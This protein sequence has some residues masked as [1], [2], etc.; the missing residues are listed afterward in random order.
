MKTF[1]SPRCVVLVMLALS[2]LAASSS[3]QVVA[4]ESM[5]ATRAVEK[6]AF[7]PKTFGSKLL[8]GSQWKKGQGASFCAKLGRK[9]LPGMR[10]GKGRTKTQIR[11]ISYATLASNYTKAMKLRT[12]TTK[13]KKSFKTLSKKY[14]GLANPRGSLYTACNSG[15][16]ARLDLKGAAGLVQEGASSRSSRFVRQGGSGNLTVV[17]SSGATRSAFSSGSVAVASITA[18]PDKKAYISLNG[19]VTIDTRSGETLCSFI[20]SSTVDGSTT[21]I[22][23]S[24]NRISNVQFDGLKRVYWN[25]NGRLYRWNR[26]GSAP[27]A[28]TNNNISIDIFIP[29]DS[30]AVI[31]SGYT[32]SNSQSWTRLLNTSGGLESLFPSTTSSFL[33]LFPDGNVYMGEMDYGIK[34]FLSDSNTVEAKYWVSSVAG[35]LRDAYFDVE[36]TLCTPR[37]SGFCGTYGTYVK[38]WA[39]VGGKVFAAAGYGSYVDLMTYYPT[40]DYATTSVT[41]V[42]MIA[43]MNSSVA[44]SGLTSTGQQRLT[45][46]DPSTDTES[47]VS[48]PETEIYNL[49]YS[50]STSELLFDGLRFSDNKYVLGTVSANGAVTIIDGNRAAQAAAVVG[51]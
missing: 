34:R 29:L 20:E 12:T 10:A 15:S 4:P 48:M 33:R 27:S 5:G 45:I 49:T 8:T 51:F 50:A 42:T 23:S 31:I 19:A 18:G 2:I 21:C 36:G 24:A 46:Y 39:T 1:T 14:S 37:H 32:R 17:T 30:G 6:K 13:Q 47:V 28:L 38:S 40:V 43:G 22:S 44:V 16:A 9:W 7:D 25:Q 3:A 41:S 35:G 26:D 11:F